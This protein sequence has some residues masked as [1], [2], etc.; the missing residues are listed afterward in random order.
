M[1]SLHYVQREQQ[2]QYLGKGCLIHS[3]LHKLHKNSPYSSRPVCLLFKKVNT[4]WN[5]QNHQQWRNG[6]LLG[7]PATIIG[8]KGGGQRHQA[9]C[10]DGSDY[11][12]SR[13]GNWVTLSF[14]L[15]MLPD[16]NL[17]LGWGWILAAQSC[18]Q[19]TCAH[20]VYYLIVEGLHIK[21]HPYRD[22][23]EL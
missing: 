15:T 9:T 22:A 4:L 23:I 20:N 19:R 8:E 5:I 7:P 12:T 2:R 11:A 3:S 18:S 13:G 16:L 17:D 6:S 1:P 10:C 21:P 14:R